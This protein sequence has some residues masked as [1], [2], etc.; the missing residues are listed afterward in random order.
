MDVEKDEQVTPI[1]QILGEKDVGILGKTPQVKV[2]N[3]AGAEFSKKELNLLLDTG[4]AGFEPSDSDGFAKLFFKLSLNKDNTTHLVLQVSVDGVRT[5][6]REFKI[7]R[8]K[9]EKA[10]GAIAATKF[11]SEI[12]TDELFTAQ[13]KVFGTDGKL[14]DGDLVEIER[15][16]VAAGPSDIPATILPTISAV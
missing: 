11:P 14:R 16:F 1:V 6:S 9:K 8:R 13:F 15:S 4:N 10:C 7:I 2:M 5:N 3:L 12:G